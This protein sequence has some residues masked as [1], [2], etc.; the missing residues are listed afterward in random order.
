MYI[1][2]KTNAHFIY[3]FLGEIMSIH[4]VYIFS[5]FLVL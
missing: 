2:I 3:I 1:Y 4:A 5:F